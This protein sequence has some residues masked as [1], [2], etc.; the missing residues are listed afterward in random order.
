VSDRDFT[1]EPGDDAVVTPTRLVVVQ[2]ESR[3]L[4]DV[5]DEPMVMTVPHLL[6]RE[7]ITVVAVCLVIVVLSL[8]MDAPLE[9]LANPQMTP[10]PSKAPWYFLGLQE[11]LHYYPPFVAGVLIPGLVIIALVIV[12]YFNVNLQRRP[13]WENDRPRKLWMVGGSVILICL[14]LH[15]VAKHS[16]WPLILSTIAVAIPMMLPGVIH[17]DGKV[18]RWLGTRSLAFWI[19]VWFVIAEVVLTV[20]GVYFRGPGWSFTLPW[21]DGVY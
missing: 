5:H 17:G 6:V 3:P 9:E 20:I 8:V 4:V 14:F 7:A 16:V 11:L 13:L 15:F 19:F 2:E 1:L 10:N 18:M 12:P 21:V